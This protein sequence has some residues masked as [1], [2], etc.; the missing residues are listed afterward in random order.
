MDDLGRDVRQGSDP[1]PQGCGVSHPMMLVR[2]R[3]G[4]ELME[5][6]GVFGTGERVLN[7]LEYHKNGM[8]VRN[9]LFSDV[10]GCAMDQRG[11]IGWDPASILPNG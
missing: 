11:M 5:R 8:D 7:G 3:S 1:N 2:D 6:L 9:W 10:F 4:C